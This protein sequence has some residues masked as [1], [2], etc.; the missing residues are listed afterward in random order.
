MKDSFEDLMHTFCSSRY[1]YYIGVGHS[2]NLRPYIGNSRRR[3]YRSHF[4]LLCVEPEFRIVYLSDPLT[5]H[6]HIY[7]IYRGPK[8]WNVVEDRSV[9]LNTPNEQCVFSKFKHSAN[10]IVI[11]LFWHHYLLI[12]VKFIHLNIFYGLNKI[13][14]N[15]KIS[16][17]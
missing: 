5:V 14:I 7:Q 10:S 2:T 3:V 4:V 11:Y 13:S 1:P 17:V 6:S 15:T 9:E 16:P 8:F 12:Y